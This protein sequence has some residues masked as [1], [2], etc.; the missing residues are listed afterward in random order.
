MI[1]TTPCNASNAR[2]SV[3]PQPSVRDVSLNNAR[4]NTPFDT[5][6]AAP[7]SKIPATINALERNV[8]CVFS[9]KLSLKSR[10]S[11]SLIRRA[12]CV[13]HQRECQVLRR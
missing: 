5:T 12:H 8:E 7:V 1:N 13:G 11:K 2:N 4:S 10:L 3:A 6:A 9:S